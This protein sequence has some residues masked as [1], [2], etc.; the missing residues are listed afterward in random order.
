MKKLLFILLCIP[1]L[2]QAQSYTSRYFHY[3]QYYDAPAPFCIEASTV[4][5]AD[6]EAIVFSGGGSCSSVQRGALV[7]AHGNEHANAGQLNIYAGDDN[8]FTGGAGSINFNTRS[9]QR[10]Q[11]PRGASAAADDLVFGD[12]GTASS[13]ATIR[14]ARADGSDDGI[15]ILTGGGAS[16]VT[17]GATATL[18][19]D[20]NSGSMY[21][22]SSSRPGAEVRVAAASTNG[23]VAFWGNGQQKWY[24]SAASGDL[25]QDATNGGAVVFNRAFPGIQY[26]GSARGVPSPAGTTQSDAT[27]MTAAQWQIVVGAN[28][29]AGIKFPATSGNFAT[30]SYVVIQNISNAVLKL[31]ADAAGTVIN[32]VAGTTAYLIAAQKT[33]TC[34]LNTS[35]DWWC[36]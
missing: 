36:A 23:Q 22:Y 16:G 32:N 34:M 17:R 25:V 8:G 2:A 12:S 33:V 13:I 18:Y 15:L 28:N 24:V 10:W 21:L 29:V 7:A 6:N 19:G 31:Y 3:D 9:I 1:V 14:G 27:A 35:T 26:V 11:I 5:G 4:D 30:G 20:D